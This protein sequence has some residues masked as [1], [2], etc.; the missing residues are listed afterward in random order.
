VSEINPN[1]IYTT[2]E[3]RELLKVSSSTLKRLLKKGIVRANKVGGQ[4]R[5]LGKELLRL[6]SPQ[7]ERK[8]VNT[9]QGL[10]RNIKSKM[11]NWL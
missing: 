7:I 1:E 3:T 5:I 8:A 4:Y 10:K 6:I 2:N 9:Y 11:K